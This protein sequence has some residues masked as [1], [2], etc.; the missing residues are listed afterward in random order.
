MASYRVISSDSHV[1]EPED[2]WTTRIDPKFKDRAPRIVH[3][4][5]DG[6]DWWVCEGVKAVSGGS[7]SGAGQRFTDPDNLLFAGALDDVRPGGYIPEDHVKDLDIDGVDTDFLYPTAGL[8]FYGVPDGD[9]V[10]A[11]FRA[12]NDWLAEFCRPFPERT[13]GIAMI[14]L[15]DVDEGVK[16]LER[17]AKLGLAGAMITIEP[18]EDRTYDSM[19]YEPL[20]AAAQDLGTPLSLHTVT[21]RYTEERGSVDLEAAGAAASSALGEH[22]VRMSLANMIFGG[23]FERYP[24]LRVGSIEYETSWVPYFLNRMDYTYTQV[25]GTTVGY[26]FQ[27]DM[28]PSDY[29]HRNCFL[30]FQEDDIGIRLRDLIGIDTLMWG[31][32]YPHPESTFPRSQQILEEILVGCTEEEKAKIAGGNCAKLYSI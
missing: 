27:E 21:N 2:L 7:G 16:E 24:K 29:F 28:T 1:F 3:R 17:S 13:K 20:W 31:S 18:P 32:D 30:G 4:D 9:L 22:A 8:L 5:E 10:S 26:R 23:V 25:P 12:Y 11:V 15:D 6:S 14:N 19:E